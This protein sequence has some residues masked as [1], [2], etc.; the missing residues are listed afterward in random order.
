MSYNYMDA[1]VDDI[2]DYINDEVE[3][4]D[5]SDLDDLR[6]KLDEDLWVTDSVTGNASGSYTF[7]RWKAR[8]YVV[9]NMDLVAEMADEFGVDNATLGEKFREEEWEYFDVSIRCYLLGQAIE[10]ALEELGIDEDSFTEVEEDEEED[11]EE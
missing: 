1:M 4:S 3:L 11:E 9:D 5:Y 8:D 6:E 10:Q 7:D 2:K